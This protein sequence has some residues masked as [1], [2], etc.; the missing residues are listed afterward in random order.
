M[1]HSIE[2]YPPRGVDGVSK[3]RDTV[4]AFSSFNPSHVSVTYGAGGSTRDKTNQ[5]V[6]MMI[7]EY[8]MH[9][10]PHLSCIGLTK[11]DVESMLDNYKEMGA[12]GI[13]ALRGDIPETECTG[14]FEYASD[15]VEF[16]MDYGHFDIHV[17]GYPDIHPEALSSQDDIHFL[18]GKVKAGAS[19]IL[20]QYFLN[21]DAYFQLRDDLLKLGVDVPLVVGVMPIVSF[22]KLLKFSGMCG[23]EIPMYIRK[24]M[25]FFAGDLKSQYELGIEI[26]SRQCEHLLKEGAPSLHFYTLNQAEPACTIWRNLL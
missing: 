14:D 2:F 21:P 6:K 5:T 11:K 22:D 19:T 8:D 12:K 7:D 18:A 17:A 24:R 1:Q 9:T 15:L 10:Y 23:A 3:L 25:E 26:L 20:T 13:V 4:A 16:I